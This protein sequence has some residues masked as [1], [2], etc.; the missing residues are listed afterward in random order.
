MKLKL[1]YLFLISATDSN[2]QNSN[3]T[4]LDINTVDQPNSDI[5]NADLQNAVQQNSNEQ[6]LNQQKAD[7]RYLNTLNFDLEFFDLFGSDVDYVSNIE[8]DPLY[9]STLDTFEKLKKRI[10]SSYMKLMDSNEE[11][12]PHI[13]K[14]YSFTKNCSGIEINLKTPE[15]LKKFQNVEINLLDQYGC[16][17][18]EKNAKVIDNKSYLHIFLTPDPKLASILRILAKYDDDHKRLIIT[19]RYLQHI[20]DYKIFGMVRMENENS[21]PLAG[22]LYFDG[23]DLKF[24]EP[25]Q[26]CV[27]DVLFCEKYGY[28]VN[29]KKKT[30]FLNVDMKDVRYLVLFSVRA[31]SYDLE[32][33]GFVVDEDI[34]E[35]GYPLMPV[36]GGDVPY[37]ISDVDCTCKNL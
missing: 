25:K 34:G 10:N 28:Y 26:I 7:K 32:E 37:I 21:V 18:K 8:I 19:S 1:L 9:K 24:Y 36:L 17:K 15:K 16:V 22:F 13:F 35:N 33:V 3:Q 12:Y 2:Q 31:R 23:F 20:V 30:Y 27:F 11:T 4:N 29:Y 5:K 14:D 6:N